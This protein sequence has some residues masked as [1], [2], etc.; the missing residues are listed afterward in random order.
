M[1]TDSSLAA[2]SPELALL[3]PAKFSAEQYVQMI[4]AGV[5]GSADRVE[6]IDGVI[7]PMAPAGPEHNASLIQFT[8][9]FAPVLDRFDL[10]VQGTVRLG[11]NQVFDPD[12]AL[13]DRKPKGY[14]DKHPT[15]SDI[16]LGIESSASSLR[17][18]LEKKL[19]VYANGS[20]GECWIADLATNTLLVHRNPSC[21]SYTNVVK[22]QSGDEVCP[23]CC[24]DLAIAVSD[25]FS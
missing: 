9:L 4:E 10:L 16:R 18:D 22:L 15:A 1:S 2:D 14:R 8:R 24:P 17:K 23:L 5:L 3:P 13:L 6:L 21:G 12:V 11:E 19:P 7:T 25:L 20:I